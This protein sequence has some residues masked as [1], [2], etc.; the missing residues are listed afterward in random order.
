M[1]CVQFPQV[2]ILVDVFKAVLQ[3]KSRGRK[4]ER[5]KTSRDGE[6]CLLT[7][8]DTLTVGQTSLYK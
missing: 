1:I 5:R 4:G 8:T 2:R 6:G 3:A 7:D